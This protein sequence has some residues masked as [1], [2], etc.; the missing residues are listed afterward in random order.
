MRSLP[1]P[2]AASPAPTATHGWRRWPHSP[3]FAD[4]FRAFFAEREAARNP[5]TTWVRIQVVEF[6]WVQVSTLRS[7][8]TP[9]L[10]AGVEA[11]HPAF[12]PR[13]PLVVDLGG[14]GPATTGRNGGQGPAPFY[15][16]ST[17]I[18]D[19]GPY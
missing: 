14:R 6:W 3:S 12:P 15:A 7:S 13:D 5:A 8:P 1:V 11:S 2:V 17:R 4:F 18:D 19:Y 9:N 16:R 10:S